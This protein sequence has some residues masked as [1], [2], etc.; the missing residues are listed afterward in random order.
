MPEFLLRSLT[1]DDAIIVARHRAAM[2]HEMGDL[3]VN[4]IDDMMAA[5]TTYLEDAI[6]RGEYYGWLASPAY[7]GAVVAGG[8]G[9]Q[10]RPQLPRP[11][12]AGR[13][14]L[15]GRQGIILNVFVEPEFRRQGLARQLIEHA[16]DWSREQRL[17]SVVLHASKAGRPLYERLGFIG[18]NEMRFTGSLRE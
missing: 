17:T 15:I 2:F 9:I 12:P 5:T 1:P 7:A 3:P 11:N 14:L 10:L 8:A 4:Q 13:G 18:T 16:L 6:A